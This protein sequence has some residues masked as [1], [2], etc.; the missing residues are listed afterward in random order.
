MKDAQNHG[1]RIRL[2]RG[3]ESILYLFQA[4]KKVSASNLSSGESFSASRALIEIWRSR[5]KKLSAQ[6]VWKSSSLHSY[7]PKLFSHSSSK[8]LL[9]L[10]NVVVWHLS[11]PTFSYFCDCLHFLHLCICISILSGNDPF[12]AFIMH[13]YVVFITWSKNTYCTVWKCPKQSHFTT[14]QGKL[15]FL[16]FSTKNYWSNFLRHFWWFSN[17]IAG[18]N[19]KWRVKVWSS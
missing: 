6:Q 17:T 9:P 18:A 7:V 12:I 19:E 8:D 16:N 5:K 14:F 2:K 4:A 10:K 13:L 1:K 11:S 3:P 15:I